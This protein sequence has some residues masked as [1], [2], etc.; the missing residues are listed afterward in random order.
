MLQ[1]VTCGAYD[2]HNRIINLQ[3]LSR[4]AATVAGVLGQAALAAR[5]LGP[6]STVI[7]TV[8]PEFHAPL[9]GQLVRNMLLLV[10]VISHTPVAAED[11]V[12]APAAC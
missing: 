12:A 8:W 1:D 10:S 11:D 3:M 4:M 6:G 5:P 7:G 2:E 9:A